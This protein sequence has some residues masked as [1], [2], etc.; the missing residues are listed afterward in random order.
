[1]RALIEIWEAVKIAWDALRKNKLRAFLTLLGIIVGVTTVIGIVSITEGLDKA[2]GEEISSLG[3]NVLYV[4]KF[5]WAQQMDWD[6]IRNRKDITMEEVE[7]L[8]NFLTIPAAIS[9]STNT[10]RT[11]KYKS[12]FLE[13]VNITGTNEVKTSDVFPEYGRD[14]TAM[15]VHHRRLVCVAGWDI[16]ETLFKNKN[17]LG[18]RIKIGGYKF[19][20]VGILEKQGDV[21]GQSLDQEVRIPI[22]VFYKLF[23]S[24]RSLTITVKVENP[25]LLDQTKGQ[26]RGILRRVRKVLP[27]EEDNFSVNQMDMIMDLYNSLTSTL[28]AAAIGVGAISLL[29]GGIGIM[30]IMLVSVTER[31]REIGIRKAIGAKR[32]NI[33]WQF[34]IESVVISAIGGIIG[35]GL[36]FGIGKV[37]ASVSPLPTTVTGWS[38]FLGIGFSS[39]VGIFF[40]LYPASKAARLNPIESLRYE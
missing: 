39:A 32:R 25:E 28:Y 35:I 17:P 21:F 5:P 30:N 19:R 13:N 36:G 26:I 33:L 9:P 2:F 40:G 18:K 3:S 11:V 27:G 10:R 4:Q 34:L 8:E 23:G 14:L 38:I 16:A 29:V 6:E 31:T 12:E 20:I 7:A 15:D 1:M 24:N 22:G 37:I